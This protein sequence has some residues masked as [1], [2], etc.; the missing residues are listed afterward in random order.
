M[1]MFMWA[2]LGGKRTATFLHGRDKR[3]KVLPEFYQQ[4]DKL[5]LL[6]Y[7]TTG[8]V[9]IKFGEKKFL[10][11]IK[12]K[13]RMNGL[14]YSPTER[15][16]TAKLVPV[17]VDVEKPGT[18]ALGKVLETTIEWQLPGS[19]KR[20][21]GKIFQGV[22]KLFVQFKLII[23]WKHDFAKPRKFN[24]VTVQYPCFENDSANENVFT[25]GNHKFA[26]PRNWFDLA[27]APVV[28]YDDELNAIIFSTL[29]HFF[30]S[31]IKKQNRTISCGLAGTV[32]QIPENFELE[33][34]IVFGKGINK[35][36]EDWGVLFRARH[37][38]SIRDPYSSPITSYLGY[39]TDNGAYYYYNTEKGM[40]YE[41]T[42]IALRKHHKDIGLPMGYYQLDSWWYPKSFESLPA[43]V[44]IFLFGSAMHW[45]EPPKPEIFPHGLK[46]V[47]EQLD[48]LPLMCHSRW[49]SPKS[50]YVKKYDFYIQKP[51]M[52]SFNL[53]L[54]AAPKN[55][56]FW[57]DLFAASKE[58]GLNC[59]LQDWL[60][61]QY[62]E[63]DIMKSTVDFADRW[64][65]NM[66]EGAAKHRMTLQYCMAPSS[67][68]M[69]G[70]K[71]PNLM[72]ARASDDHNGM[73]PRRWYQPHFTQTSMLCHAV[74]FWPHK[75]TFASSTR[76]HYWFYGERF[77]EM[78]CITAV[79]SGGPVAP[80]DKIGYEDKD[81]LMKSCRADGLLLKPDKPAT[82]VDMMF[83][84]HANYYITSTHSRKPSGLT[85]YYVHFMNLWPKRVKERAICTR[86][87][88]I[89]GRRLAYELLAKR[90]TVLHQPDDCMPL[91]VPA[92]GQELVIFCPEVLSGIYIIGN[93]EKF[94]TCSAK[95]FPDV[96]VDD[97]GTSATV[98]VEGVPGETV[99]V[100]VYYE[101]SIPSV[102][103]TGVESSPGPLPSTI[104]VKVTVG[105]AGKASMTIAS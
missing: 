39:N 91:D 31:G 67:F 66:A 44:K 81:L 48:K 50:D 82:P 97:T 75:D 54:F 6:V 60:S 10:R 11:G 51:T 41:D 26:P 23:P 96:D 4:D 7:D 47:W 56:D 38:T 88:D 95:Q 71:L 42:M 83:K 104:V 76:K 89:P 84:D 59:F 18:T 43:L 24:D 15:N 20:V 65:R 28:L 58:W 100:L 16:K 17:R 30:V 37:G 63:I 78:E 12:P 64:T 80:S 49:F 93:H 79:L 61:Y 27:A 29:D 32:K 72:Q 45:G 9:D 77:P 36:I 103:G 22:D 98:H 2:A 90:A 46:Y 57:D 70:V 68:M 35:I 8:V 33:S 86:S 102:K 101:N 3:K 25:W 94:V 85:W 73:Q 19:E 105:D 13:L 55:I 34:I 5:D 53:P 1:T 74:G 21:I 92:S 99:S 40:N 52:K 62:D 87:L 14:V 69:Q